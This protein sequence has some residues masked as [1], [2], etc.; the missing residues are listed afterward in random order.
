MKTASL[1]I[2]APLNPL[3]DKILSPQAI[4]FL[5]KLHRQFNAKRLD[6]LK[7]RELK[8]SELNQ[9][10]LPEFVFP[11]ETNWQVAPTPTDLQQRWVEITG[12]TDRKMV[13]NALNSGADVFMADFEDANSPTWKNLI[14]GQHNLIEAIA[15]DLSLKTPE[16]KEYRLNPKRA[17]L[18]V[19]PRGWHLPEGHVMVDDEPMSGALFDFGLYFFHNAQQLIAKGSGPYFYL[20]KLENHLEARLWNEVFLFAQQELNIPRGTI[21]ATVLLETILAAFE[22]DSI[23]YELREHSAGL[24]AG[25]WDY[26]FS[27]IKKFQADH[28][29]VLP[30]RSQIN[31]RVPFM[32]AY[33]QL[34]VQTCHRRNAHAIGGM[35]AFIPSRRDKALNEQ[36]LAKVREDKLLESSLGFDGTWVAHPDLVAGAKEIFNN[37]LQGKPNQNKVIPRTTVDEVDLL[38]FRVHGG[39]ITE[40]GM[41]KN[42]NIS[43]QYLQAWLSGIG[44][45]AL[46]NLMEDAATAEISR[47]QLWQ[48]LHNGN[49]KLEHG[50]T[51]NPEL[52][53]DFVEQEIEKIAL[54]QPNEKK[55]THTLSLARQ[56]LDELVLQKHFIEFMT[57]PAYSLLLQHEDR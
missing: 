57:L 7:Q 54:G 50:Q 2:K 41:R 1:A 40:E 22:M 11:P 24:N 49:V 48:W 3:T 28:D 6:L 33:T 8:Q 5:T 38:N 44:A 39:K 47:A 16:G 17:V 29:F 51:I 36:A 19:R 37:F 12:P 13:I 23:L 42:I 45:V 18:M 34:L 43:L 52:Y 25:R 27:I 20:A 21:R 53:R 15:G 56:V 32:K 35:A 9:G 14:E 10:T 46:F 31:M 26:I 55:Y 4:E 30:D